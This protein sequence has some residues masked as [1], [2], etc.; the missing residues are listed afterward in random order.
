MQESG[1]PR[2]PR[3]FSTT[4][5][6]DI[7]SHQDRCERVWFLDQFDERCGRPVLAYAS[8]DDPVWNFARPCRYRLHTGASAANSLR[9]YSSRN[10]KDVEGGV[11]VKFFEEPLRT[12]NGSV[13]FHTEVAHCAPISG[14]V[15]RII[16]GGGRTQQRRERGG[17][18]AT[19]SPASI[20]WWLRGQQSKLRL[21]RTSRS[22]ERK[23]GL[24]IARF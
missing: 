16:F 1:V 19:L 12:G 13:S 23:V 22:V 8:G 24:M 5:S 18:S 6:R 14:G 7:A 9:F 20:G 2:L 10:P 3:Y 11:A 21:V 4:H 17:E 15:A